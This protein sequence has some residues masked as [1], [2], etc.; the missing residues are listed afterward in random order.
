MTGKIMYQDDVI[1]FEIPDG[2]KVSERPMPIMWTIKKDRRNILTID[3]TDHFNLE[4]KK[5]SLIDSDSV[6]LPYIRI[7]PQE[8][9]F[10]IG[11][12][13]YG[14]STRNSDNHYYK[15]IAGI[16]VL[17]EM[18]GIDFSI[19]ANTDFDI[20]EYDDLFNSIK[21]NEE[22]YL[23]YKE[24]F[25]TKANSSQDS[26]KSSAKLSKRKKVQ[27]SQK[28]QEILDS[29]D[30]ATESP[31]L[32]L[33]DLEHGYFYTA[34]SRITLFGDDSRWAIAF[35]KTGYNNRGLEVQIEV[36]YFGNCLMN[37]DKAGYDNAFTC[38]TKF[39]TLIDGDTIK[40]LCS[41]F[42]VISPDAES[43]AVRNENILIEHDPK[44]Y[45]KK[46]IILKELN[47]IDIVA[48]TRFFDE[49]HPDLF[50]ASDDELYTC[51][52]EDLP[53]IMVIDEWHQPAFNGKDVDTKPS[54][55]ELF[56]L[57]AEVLASLDP[58]KWNPKLKLNSNW[59]NWP[60]AGGL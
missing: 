2:Y 16:I 10:S 49:T 9:S 5:W 22:R 55:H 14:G 48:L 18:Y 26:S 43:I 20:R 56:Q 35:E 21:I 60:D 8:H 58:T 45:R 50:R 40:E 39:F 42:E 59:R 1:T 57:I 52:P 3:I 29:F 19:T 23:H 11:T 4:L 7:T 6:P 28:S 37:L 54:E 13:Y 32:F 51:I 17:N 30:N 24:T 34:G 47:E 25:V 46:K 31:Y 53:K 27:R 38:N 41:D 36:N 44:I 15:F 12:A 33:P